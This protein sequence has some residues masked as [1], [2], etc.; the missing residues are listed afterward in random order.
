M[1][2]YSKELGTMYARN[3]ARNYAGIY[4]KKLARNYSIM[5]AKMLPGI[6]QEGMHER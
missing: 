1:K 2:E 6:N 5:Y 4:A 3:V